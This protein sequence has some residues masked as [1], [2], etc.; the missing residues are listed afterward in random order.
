MKRTGLALLIHIDV[1]MKSQ[2]ARGLTGA[3]LGSILLAAFGGAD[4]RD[5]TQ[6]AKLV[7]VGDILSDVGSYRVGT[8]AALGG[9]RHTVNG[10]GKIC[11][12]LLPNNC[13]C[14]NLALRRPAWKVMPPRA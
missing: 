10:A 1:T 8:V 3:L 13:D 14:P 5:N 12:E 11:V 6:Y 4:D 9:G 7:S 2:T